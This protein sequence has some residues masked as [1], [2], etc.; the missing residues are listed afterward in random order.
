[1]GLRILISGSLN[2]LNALLTSARPHNNVLFGFRI[3]QRIHNEH[4]R[5]CRTYGRDEYFIKRRV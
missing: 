2:L 1:M 3:Y 4:R 5:C